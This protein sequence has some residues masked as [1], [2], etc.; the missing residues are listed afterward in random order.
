M[1]GDDLEAD[2]GGG[3]LLPD[4]TRVGVGDGVLLPEGARVID[5]MVVVKHKAAANN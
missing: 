2:P 4:G 1:T 5:D 3:V